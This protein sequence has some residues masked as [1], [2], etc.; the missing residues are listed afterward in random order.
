ML[1]MLRKLVLLALW[2]SPGVVAV[3]SFAVNHWQ[4]GIGASVLALFSVFMIGLSRAVVD[5]H[6]E[7]FIEKTREEEREK[8]LR[9]VA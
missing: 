6:G 9:K 4:A 5:A 2:T 3:Y 1:N 8:I 7:S